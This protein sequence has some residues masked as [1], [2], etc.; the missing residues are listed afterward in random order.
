MPSQREVQ[1]LVASGAAGSWQT[2]NP[3]LTPSKV[4][5]HQSDARRGQALSHKR[6]CPAGGGQTLCVLCLIIIAGQESIREML[7]IR[8]KRISKMTTMMSCVLNS[9]TVSTAAVN[10]R[11]SQLPRQQQQQQQVKQHCHKSP[12]V[13]P[14][15]GDLNKKYFSNALITCNCCSLEVQVQQQQQQMHTSNEQFQELS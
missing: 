3:R 9:M 11:S 14:L 10:Q 13:R 2:I 12:F 8:C 4:N 6:Q 5:T 1:S 15:Q 7:I